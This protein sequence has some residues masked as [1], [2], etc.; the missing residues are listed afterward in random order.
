[1]ETLAETLLL[2]IAYL[3]VGGTGAIIIFLAAVWFVLFV[4]VP[5]V[6]RWRG[7]TSKSDQEPSERPD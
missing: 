4:V 1:M 5:R 6:R 2:M 3:F 7:R